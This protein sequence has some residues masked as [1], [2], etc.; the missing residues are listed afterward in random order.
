MLT[1]E[2]PGKEERPYLLALLRAPGLNVAGLNRL[3][4]SGI[5]PSS[6]FAASRRWL[7]AQGIRPA[8]ADYLRDPPWRAVEQELRWLEDDANHLLTPDNPCYPGLL[9]QIHDPPLALYVRGNP[10]ALN[11]VQLAVVGSR[12]PSPGGSRLARRFAG[13]LSELGLTITSGLARGIDSQCHKG[14]IDVQGITV[15][16]LGNGLGTVY[17]ASNSRLADSV[18]EQGA[19]V[20]EFPLDYRPIPANF[21][22]RNRIIS[23]MST[24]VLVVEAALKSGS[25]ITARCAMEQ[26]REVFAIPGS[27]HN[28]LARGSHLL[29]RQGA[30]LVEQVEDIIEEIG[31]LAAAAQN[32]SAGAQPVQATPGGLDAEGKLLLDNMG[33]DPVSVDFLVDETGLSAEVAGRSLLALELDGLVES[34]PGGNYVRKS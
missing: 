16:V 34:L 5:T 22:R 13:Q 14:V 17:P 7:L 31:M 33:Y 20:S 6:L 32:S 30:K 10:A 27:I 3:F 23:G 15:A 21:P 9:K 28:P 29:I 12:N 2:C 8:T 18:L 26:G 19:L 24:G 4:R 11:S 1:E 25:L